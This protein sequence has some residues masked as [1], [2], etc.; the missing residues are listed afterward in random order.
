MSDFNIY[1]IDNWAASTYY[2]KNKI[3]K[4]NN[5]FYYATMNHTSTSSLATDLSN[6]L[7]NGYIT[8]KGESKPYFTWIP[9]YSYN[10]DNQPRIKKIQLGD[11]YT[12]RSPDGINN[13]LPVFNLEFNCDINE[14]TAILHFLTERKGSESFIW[15]APAPFGT[16]G[17]FVCEKFSN[18]QPFYNNYTLNCTFERSIT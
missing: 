15:L 18:V 17:R 9:S 2:Y 10:V 14:V 13:I 3:V 1:L 8:D 16:L 4:N 12:Q 5:L 11:G 6:N 7:W